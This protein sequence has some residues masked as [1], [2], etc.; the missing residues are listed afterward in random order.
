MGSRCDET[1]EMAV[2]ESKR[3]WRPFPSPPLTLPC[4]LLTSGDPELVEEGGQVLLHLN[5]VVLHLWTHVKE[6]Q[7]VG[8]QLYCHHIHKEVEEMSLYKRDKFTIW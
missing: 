7:E 8:V 6:E 1:Q 2:V 3:N 4:P 5:T